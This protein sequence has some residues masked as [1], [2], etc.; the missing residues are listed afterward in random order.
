MAKKKA[1]RVGR[2]GRSRSAKNKSTRKRA[3][4]ARAAARK[5]F[6][7]ATLTVRKAIS[8]LKGKAKAAKAKNVKSRFE[9]KIKAMLKT[10]R[11]ST[12]QKV[13]VKG[14]STGKSSTKGKK[15][16]RTSKLKKAKGSA[17][18]KQR[19]TN[20]RTRKSPRRK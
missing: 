11:S 6:L 14:P 1:R 5:K 3:M 7:K 2:I 17:K 13:R 16:V 8:T 18:A 9:N 20:K 19:K 12:L 10:L 4:A 15:T